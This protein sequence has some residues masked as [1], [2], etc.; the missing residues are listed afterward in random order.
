M[1][2]CVYDCWGNPQGIGS[3]LKK[4]CKTMTPYPKSIERK[5]KT[6]E[7]HLH[8]SP[9]WEGKE[10]VPRNSHSSFLIDTQTWLSCNTRKRKH[11][12]SHFEIAVWQ[13]AIMLQIPGQRSNHGNSFQN[14][15]DAHGGKK[16]SFAP[17]ALLCRFSSLRC[18][19][20]GTPDA[21][22]DTFSDAPRDHR[23]A[24]G[25]P[26]TLSPLYPHG[27]LLSFHPPSRGVFLFP[28]LLMTQP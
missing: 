15:P 19:L 1:W 11:N 21:D 26:F 6:Y 9:S 4:R 16:G 14:T 5:K 13:P 3:T 12:F 10:C 2:V 24:P 25:R 18:Q 7:T 8:K 27:S 28:S 17:L 22:R 23:G 20:S